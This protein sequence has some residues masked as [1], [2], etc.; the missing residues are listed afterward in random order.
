MGLKAY[1]NHKKCK[2]CKWALFCVGLRIGPLLYFFL[3]FCPAPTPTEKGPHFVASLNGLLNLYT[4]PSRINFHS[5]QS[6]PR[7]SSRRF[8][9]G[10][11]AARRFLAKRRRGFSSSFPHFFQRKVNP[12][13]CFTFS[14][15]DAR[16]S[17]RPLSSPRQLLHSPSQEASAARCIPAPW[18]SRS[19]RTEPCA[20][21]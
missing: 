7:D 4:E 1:P 15:E 16:F 10:S 8:L 19:A 21:P 11:R 3:P 9:L 12:T 20:V 6:I 14:P 5:H 18:H 13:E 2:H 17:Q